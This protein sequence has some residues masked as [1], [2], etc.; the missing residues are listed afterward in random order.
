[1]KLGICELFD[2]TLILLPNML[3][4]NLMDKL[5][6]RVNI[7]FITGRRAI[8]GSQFTVSPTLS[9]VHVQE[10]PQF[11]AFSSNCCG[12]V[13][14]NILHKARKTIPLLGVTKNLSCRLSSLLTFLSCLPWYP[15][16][17]QPQTKSIIHSQFLR[18]IIDKGFKQFDT[19]TRNRR[20]CTIRILCYPRFPI[21]EGFQ[22]WL[23]NLLD[24]FHLLGSLKWSKLLLIL[25]LRFAISSIC[26]GFLLI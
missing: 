2:R 17:S 14:Q 19:G 25:V 18:H 6:S 10:L 12:L 4:M 8:S 21:K 20:E 7:I 5:V 11:A 16:Q 15:N 13:A 3:Y 26:V 24:P 22:R 9:L 1:M 23:P